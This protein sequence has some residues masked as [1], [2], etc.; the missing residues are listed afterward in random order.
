[1]RSPL[2]FWKI[3]LKGRYGFTFDLMPRSVRRM[4]MLKRY[5]VLRAGGNLVYR[6][7]RP[8]SWPL[9][10]QIELA[11]Y[12]DLN[13]PVCPTGIGEM[14]RDPKAMDVS[15]FE[16]L[17]EELGPYLLT[18]SL[19][20]W[21]GPLLHPRLRDIYKAKQS[22]GKFYP[23]MSFG[24]FWF[25]RRLESIRRMI[26]DVPESLSFCRNC[27]YADRWA[28][29]CSIRAFNLGLIFNEGDTP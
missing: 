17:M 14:K 21:G 20:A 15:L 18:V 26:R 5:N 23:E 25:G 1:M 8:W 4:S 22:F 24:D 16:H 3:L 27:P 29:A 13:C 9:H 28:R 11:N 7:L 2:L 6:R 12:C 19:W 10:M